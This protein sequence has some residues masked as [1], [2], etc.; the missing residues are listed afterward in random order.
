MLASSRLAIPATIGLDFSPP[1]DSCQKHQALHHEELYISGYY[2]LEAD[3]VHTPP[4]DEQC[5]AWFTKSLDGPYVGKHNCINKL[6]FALSDN[7]L[8]RFMKFYTALRS[9]LNN[10][11]FKPICCPSFLIQLNA[12][13]IDNP[14]SLNCLS[15]P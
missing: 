2:Y 9:S 13:L 10:C 3:H 8:S 14:I 15:L 1:E 5:V 4:A 6:S 12:N 11:G 7:T